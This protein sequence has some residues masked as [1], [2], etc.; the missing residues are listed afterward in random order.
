MLGI[1]TYGAIRAAVLKVLQ[2]TVLDLAVS[3]ID[4]SFS[5][6]PRNV[7]RS[8]GFLGSPTE[9]PLGCLHAAGE[10]TVRALLDEKSFVLARPRVSKPV[11]KGIDEAR[12]ARGVRDE[13]GIHALPKER[14][15][16][17][18]AFSNQVHKNTRSDAVFWLQ[19]IEAQMKRP[20]A[21]P[22][23]HGQCK[24]KRELTRDSCFFGKKT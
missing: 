8:P 11:R 21:K 1:D 12:M 22:R 14:R 18:V 9:V 15:L 10:V 23:R 13:D 19:W 2:E 4:S 7:Q 17:T 24:P 20:M 5:F 16:A 6:G 3:R